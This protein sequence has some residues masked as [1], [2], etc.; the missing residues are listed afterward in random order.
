MCVH[1]TATI[2]VLVED[3]LDQSNNKGLKCRKAHFVKDEHITNIIIELVKACQQI[4]THKYSAIV[5]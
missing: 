5:S 3:A 4:H 1:D 2:T